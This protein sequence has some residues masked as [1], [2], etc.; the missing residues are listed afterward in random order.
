V[1]TVA[2]IQN[3]ATVSGGQ[4]WSGF[5]DWSFYNVSNSP[6]LTGFI[7]PNVDIHGVTTITSLGIVKPG[8][9][10][11]AYGYLMDGSQRLALQVDLN[12]F[13]SLQRQGVTGDPAHQPTGDPTTATNATTGGTVVEKI[14]W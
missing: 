6:S 8:T 5:S 13:L 3:P 10:N 1:F 12:A 4:P 14:T 2:Q 11:I 9:L 7:A